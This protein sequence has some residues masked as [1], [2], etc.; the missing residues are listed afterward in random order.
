[1]P[2]VTKIWKS[3]RAP[4]AKR[5][6]LPRCEARKKPLRPEGV[7]PSG[8][9]GGEAAAL[10]AKVYRSYTNSRCTRASTVIVPA[11]TSVAASK[12]TN[13]AAD[14]SKLRSGKEGCT[15]V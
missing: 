9:S 2:C 14:A 1:M 11:N 10:S 13:L 8:R 4:R 15:E 6:G 5:R 7:R 3:W 12:A